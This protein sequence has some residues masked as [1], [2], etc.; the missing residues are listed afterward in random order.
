M[1]KKPL[2]KMR[3]VHFEYRPGRPVFSGLSLEIM[4]GESICILGA[5]GAGKSTL[6][7]ILAGLLFPSSGYFEAFGRELTERL[8]EDD[9]FAQQYHRRVGFIFQNADAQLL[10]TR[11]WDEIAFGPL[12]LGLHPREV[13]TRI[14]DVMRML[15]ISE[16]KDRSPYHL[17]QGEKKRVAVASVLVM[18]PQVLLLD[19][20]TSGLDPKSQRWLVE[21]LTELKQ[22]HRTIVISTHDLNLAHLLADRVLLISED[23]RLVYDGP[24]QPVLADTRLL[25]SVNLID[26]HL[27]SHDHEQH[28]HV[29]VHR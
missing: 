25:A 9:R 21:I 22:N 20:P 13:E 8:M 29:Y 11:V 14:E 16:L 27:H 28:V 6:L 5:N 17:S 26:E 12:Q 19:E 23:H 18:T 4:P 1:K 3:D 2:F 7:K 15:E 24:S 10:T